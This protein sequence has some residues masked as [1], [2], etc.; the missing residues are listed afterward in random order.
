[1]D[2]RGDLM[3]FHWVVKE[4]PGMPVAAAFGEALDEQIQLQVRQV[5]QAYAMAVRD[6]ANQNKQKLRADL[7]AGG[8][9]QATRLSKTWRANVYPRNGGSLDPALQLVNKAGDILETFSQGA[10]IVPHGRTYL[11]VPLDPA[12]VILRRLNQ[13]KNRTRTWG[14]KFDNEDTSVHRVE[15]ALGIKLIPILNRTTG[16]GVLIADG[17]YGKSGK[18]LKRQGRP[19]PF[20]ALVR[21]ATLAKRIEGT[22][23]LDRLELSFLDDF[24]KAVGPRLREVGQEED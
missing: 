17:T 16:K 21:Q 22:A 15:R 13:A 19:T 1:M 9:Y 24:T 11:A 5:A 10:T 14:G 6:V 12:K 3:R 4:K 8:F 18:R 20:F 7:A 23:L 2:D